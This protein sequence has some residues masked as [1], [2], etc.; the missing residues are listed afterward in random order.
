MLLYELNGSSN[1]M[2]K[3]LIH[4]S[5]FFSSVFITVKTKTFKFR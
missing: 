5:A 1:K 2:N 4:L 3:S